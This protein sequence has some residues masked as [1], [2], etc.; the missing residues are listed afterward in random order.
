MKEHILHVVRLE[1]KKSGQSVGIFGVS[2]NLQRYP[3]V[4]KPGEGAW[5]SFYVWE[6]I[7]M[8]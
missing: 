1:G 4:T 8:I 6:M 5:C 2:K 3:E 7:I